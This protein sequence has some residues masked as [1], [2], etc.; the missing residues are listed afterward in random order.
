M[1]GK[2]AQADDDDEDVDDGNQ[3]TNF[4]SLK[5]NLIYG[6]FRKIETLYLYLHEMLNRIVY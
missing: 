1:V 2:Q 4:I 5:C 3:V 6:N